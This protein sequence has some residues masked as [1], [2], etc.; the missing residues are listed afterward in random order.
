MTQYSYTVTFDP[1]NTAVDISS[2][3]EWFE[4]VE[5]GSGK[6]RNG[7]MMLNGLLGAFM[8]NT[9]SGAT[10]LVDEYNLIQISLTDE[11]STT[12]TANYEVLKDRPR[13]G[14]SIG[15]LLQVDLL[16]PEHHL[17]R[18]PV[19]PQSSRRDRADSAYTKAV[20]IIDIYNDQKGSLQPSISAHDTTANTLP[21]F[22]ANHY[23]FSLSPI[24]AYD[25]LQYINDRV[26][27]SR[28]AGGG[29]ELWEF[30][31]NR[32]S[33]DENDIKYYSTISGSVDSGV[34][35]SRT[36]GVN[37]GEEEGGN[38][39][40]RATVEATWGA[41]GRGT[42]PPQ[43]GQFRDA[44]TAWRAMPDWESGVTYPNNSII[45]RRNTSPDSQGDDLHFKSNKETSSTPPVSE[46]SNTDWDTYTFLSFLTNEISISGT[47]SP[48]TLNLD[49]EWKCSGANPDG[50]QNDDPPLATSLYVWDMN[51]VTYDGSFFRDT[52]HVRATSPAGIPT[53]YLY[54]GT[55]PYRAFRVLVDGTGTGDFAGF[56][57]N[58]IEY[59]DFNDEWRLFRTTADGEYCAID[60]EAK[61]YKKSSG[62]WADDSGSD[63]ANDCY[64]P[65][66]NISNVTGHL[67]KSNGAGG[68]FGD[69]SA[70]QYQFRYA[71]SDI[72][73]PSS[74]VFYRAGACINLKAPFPANSYN[75]ATIGSVYGNDATVREPVT[76][77]TNNLDY[78]SNSKRGYNHARADEYGQYSAIRFM[79][80]F[81]WRFKLDGS[82]S[83]VSAGNI[84]CKCFMRDTHN[85]VVTADF[86]ISH[87][88]NWEMITIPFSAFDDYRARIPLSIESL[89]S[90]I[91]LNELEIL[92]EFD[93]QN[94]AEI[95]FQWMA[96][97]DEQGRYSLILATFGTLYPSLIDILTLQNTDGH[98]IKWKIDA[99]HFVK[100]LL[101]V[102]A[103]VTT[104]RAMFVDFH[105]EPLIT[106][107][108]QND[109]ANLA[110]LEQDQFRLRDFEVITDGKLD[111]N[112][113]E[114]FTLNNDKIINDADNGANTLNLVAKEIKYT[115]DKPETGIGGFIRTIRAVKRLS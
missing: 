16:G 63:K 62:T 107:R 87:N 29:G 23:P 84:G 69:S 36:T 92:Q 113:F 5:T 1:D 111:I 49:D 79:T 19:S 11:D 37:A 104:G 77:D 31:F 71:A 34:T 90:N 75:G 115:V 8:T 54:S 70:V 72:A 60:D 64:H 105:E 21:K 114:Q 80:D 102:S 66:Y 67:S 22:T 3:V 40:T 30:G 15:S 108:F 46:T 68:T 25:A 96:P 38:E 2:H 82:G 20:E 27:S 78:A 57:N 86:T 26:S 88:N 98:N 100:P 112:L 74:R 50:T 51:K 103:P 95:G 45:R 10:P 110:Y 109:Q 94:I 56:D 24:K 101:S 18:F 99:F 85:N 28:A 7:T 61:V 55:A 39:A 97:Y 44:L 4:V 17:L 83:L 53:Q 35:I 93:Y 13:D 9:N 91:F 59:D 42:N 58:I 48:W 14:V 6:V 12:F 52:A 73:S 65:V 47:Y 41:T 33:A 32:N 76:F 106:N 89:G 81:E 43:V